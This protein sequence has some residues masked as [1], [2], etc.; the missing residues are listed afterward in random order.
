[1]QMDKRNCDGKPDETKLSKEGLRFE[2]Q[3]AQEAEIDLGK[4]CISAP[5]KVQE[6]AAQKPVN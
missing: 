4:A 2:P 1:M 3:P 6:P 5:A